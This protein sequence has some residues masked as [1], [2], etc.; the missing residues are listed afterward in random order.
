MNRRTIIGATLA[1]IAAAALPLGLPHGVSASGYNTL[2]ISPLPIA[3][4]GTLTAS[5]IVDLCVQPEQSGAHVAGATVWLS[6][7][8]GKFTSPPA[9]GGTAMVGGTPL[10]S[11]PQAFTSGSATQ[12][13][14]S[15]GG[16]VSKAAVL[17]VYTAPATLPPNG[18]DIIV[19]AD[20]SADSGSNGVCGGGVCDAGTYVFSPVAS[21]AF[22]LTPIATTG[23]LTAGQ[24]VALTVTALDNSTPTPQPVP[25][26][27]LDLSIG[28]A[29]GTAT[30]FNEIS[31]SLRTLTNSPQR[32][33]ALSDG[34]VAITYKAANPLPS[35]GVDTI[36]AQ[37]HPTETVESTTSYTYATSTAPP[38]NPYTAV[39]PSRVCDTRPVR[40][41]IA[42]NQCNT[43]AGSGPIGPGAA[44]AITVDGLGGLPASGVT[45]VVVNATAIAP[46]KN[47]FITFYPDLQSRPAT[48]NLNPLA[49]QVVANLVEVGVSSAGKIDVF[50]DVGTTNLALDIEGYVSSSSTGLFTSSPSGPVRICDT[51]HAG[52][53]IASNRCNTGGASPIGGGATLTFNVN[54]SGSPVPGSGVSAVV[55]NLTAIG[56]TTRTVLTAFAGGTSRPTAS[57][58]NV[59]A[60]QA[61]PN[62]VIVPV[63]CTGGNCSVSIWNSVGSV[64]IAVDIN[65]WFTTGSGASFT[66]LA[67]PARVCN[68][69]FGNAGDQGCLK[70][71]VG[72]GSAL[73][74]AVT[75]IGN[76]PTSAVAI[77]ANVT[78]VNATSST[79]ATV[80]PGLLSRPTAS[81]LNVTSFEPVTNLVVVGVGSDGTINLFNDLGKVNFIVD[82]LGYY[83]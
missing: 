26:A 54:G 72:G 71:L 21:Y 48:S 58:V 67:A 16:S 79:F 41:G 74:I 70:A 63:T 69:Q 8:A 44:R 28:N 39:A 7:V 31:G 56:P 23:S 36:T 82:V 55:F 5:Q 29:G 75:N 12:T 1:L 57:N 3:Q 18:R 77:V 80:Y 61:V 6:L 32:V 47:T 81:D 13:C 33:G 64:N 53:G 37:N 24:S 38:S 50:N 68:T 40:P 66:A 14:T 11:T 42:S 62:R 22:S 4:P 25:G 9:A 65:G 43:G 35:S 78:V 83:S 27:Y 76:I 20:S 51:R 73:N 45:A 15:S 59:E 46:T 10:T 60:H 52:P 17:V 30:A 19:A 2:V 34:S 49:G